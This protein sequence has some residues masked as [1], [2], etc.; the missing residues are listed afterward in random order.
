LGSSRESLDQEKVF[1]KRIRLNCT[2]PIKKCSKF[3]ALGDLSDTN[4]EWEVESDD[5]SSNDEMRFKSGRNKSKGVKM[6]DLEMCDDSDDVST[7]SEGMRSHCRNERTWVRNQDL[8]SSDDSDEDHSSVEKRLKNKSLDILRDT[9]FILQS[10]CT[11][12][13]RNGSMEQNCELRKKPKK[14]GDKQP[15]TSSTVCSFEGSNGLEGEHK[16]LSFIHST[17][18]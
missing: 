4:D 18:L 7:C 17:N 1:L 10:K 11:S 14:S 3:V 8:D 15:L 2:E 12:R 9:C 13:G 5:V 16:Y 6:E